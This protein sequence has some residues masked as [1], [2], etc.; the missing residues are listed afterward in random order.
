ML[1]LGAASDVTFQLTT[2]QLDELEVY[3][4]VFSTVSRHQLMYGA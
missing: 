2:F 4:V 3:V 1:E